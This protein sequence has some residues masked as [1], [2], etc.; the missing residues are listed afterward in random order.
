MSKTFG[1]TKRI[2]EQIK[3]PAGHSAGFFIC[4]IRSS[5]AALIYK[6]TNSLLFFIQ[7]KKLWKLRMGNATC[8]C[9]FTSVFHRIL[10]FKT[11]QDFHPA[12]F[13]L[14]PFTNVKQRIPEINGTIQRHR[15]Y[16]CLS[17]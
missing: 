4:S 8:I 14:L 10:D 11:G 13:L 15:S 1:R 12:L 3:N 17:K 9:I 5:T 2:V 6:K 7:I 16:S